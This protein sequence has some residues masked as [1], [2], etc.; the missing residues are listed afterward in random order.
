MLGYLRSLKMAGEELEHQVPPR[1]QHIC[2]AHAD[3]GHPASNAFGVAAA[4]SP[5]AACL[6]ARRVVVGPP[7]GTIY[8]SRARTRRP[9]DPPCTLEFL[10]GFHHSAGREH[11]I[12]DFDKH[13]QN[14]SALGCIA[15]CQVAALGSFPTQIICLRPGTRGGIQSSQSPIAFS[16]RVP[17]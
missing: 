4:I 3:E 10:R 15:A 1:S 2:L 8:M 13:L 5:S 11:L 16:A 17:R 14:T 7:A 9:P 6:I 12:P